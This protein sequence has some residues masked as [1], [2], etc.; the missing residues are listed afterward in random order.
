M[1]VT[2]RAARKADSYRIAELDY[3][4]SGGAAE[5]LFRDLVPGSTPVEVVAHG[6]ENDLSPHSYRNAIVAEFNDEVVGMSLSYPAEYHR[7]DDEMRS[8]FP[9]ER[10]EHFKEFFSARVEDS[11]LLDA[12]CVDKEHRGHGVGS[13]LLS[14]TIERARENGFSNLSLIVFGDNQKAIR[15]YVGHGFTVVRKIELKEHE[16]IPHNAGCLLM[17]AEFA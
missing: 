9:A 17:E 5:Y 15:F 8:F 11:F 4:A 14:R 2:Y 16:L 10:L 12:L 13:E 1:N 7:I 6:L 3:I